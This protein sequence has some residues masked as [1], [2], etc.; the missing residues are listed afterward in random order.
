MATPSVII[1]TPA[2]P[3]L[4]PAGPAV[5]VRGV[6]VG[7]ILSS[8]VG[9]LV[10]VIAGIVLMILMAPRHTRLSVGSSV[11]HVI[12]IP[13][14]GSIDVS[15]PPRPAARS[16]SS[17]SGSSGGDAAILICA[18]GRFLAPAAATATLL[19]T[20]LGCRLPI[21]IWHAGAEER[22]P[23]NEVEARAEH[24]LRAIPD[25]SWHDAAPPG[26]A[27]AV[28]GASGC[29][30]KAFA[31]Y[32]TRR[33]V[34]IVMDADVVALLDPARL[35]SHPA[36]RATGALF[37]PDFGNTRDWTVG[38]TPRRLGLPAHLHDSW[39]CDASLFVMDRW[40]HWAGMHVAMLLNLNH[41]LAYSMLKGDKDTFWLALEL[42]ND[43]DYTR[44]S[45]F[46]GALRLLQCEAGGGEGG[47]E[48]G[49]AGACPASTHMH[50]Q[51]LPDPADPRKVWWTHVHGAPRLA[52]LV[53]QSGHP[54][55]HQ[56]IG[57]FLLASKP[58]YQQRTLVSMA[59]AAMAR[60]THR[61]RHIGS[62][63]EWCEVSAKTGS[64]SVR[65]EDLPLR[66]LDQYVQVLLDL[67]H[68][69]INSHEEPHAQA[70]S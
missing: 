69:A 24:A 55:R 41:S 68:V 59:T 52:S 61:A 42:A 12:R 33:R 67:Q 15:K 18:G 29:Q 53:R 28:A 27:F 40:R 70:V 32:Q 10:L 57:A 54:V 11:A 60:I 30:I 7:S 14:F 48:C 45:G 63:M 25:V 16:S 23:N 62:G 34:A 17:S 36:F 38:D 56:V 19:R 58:H 50:L 5:S 64:P 22:I 46:S 39:C 65:P 20:H 1:P 37:F 8:I 66:L 13:L 44:V 43:A 49:S 26:S 9:V 35:L 21:E 6:V 51:H 4:V 47:V 2:G 31:L 3:M